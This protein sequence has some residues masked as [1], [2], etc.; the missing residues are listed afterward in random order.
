MVI[1]RELFSTALCRRRPVTSDVPHWSVMGL[2]LLH[3]FINYT[4]DGIE[5]TL[6]KFVNKTKLSGAVDTTEVRDT[7]ERDLDRLE[8]KVHVN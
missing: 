1:A 5:C 4:D 2:V 6:S 3:M 7:I 8:K